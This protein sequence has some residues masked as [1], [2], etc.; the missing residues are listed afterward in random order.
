LQDDDVVDVD[1]DMTV[2]DAP[3]SQQ[4]SDCP[5]K[6]DGVVDV[7]IV[8]DDD[9]EDV[10]VELTEPDVP[11]PQQTDSHGKDD[12]VDVEWTEPDAPSSQHSSS[13]RRKKE[14]EM[15]M[16]NIRVVRRRVIPNEK[17]K[18]GKPQ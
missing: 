15:R 14:K 10:V 7:D 5:D 1:V 13:A 11:S 6:E 2:P 4:T 17:E 9:V 18:L 3:S 12:V 16:R 8:Q